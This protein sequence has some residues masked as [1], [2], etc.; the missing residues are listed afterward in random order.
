MWR[1][2]S[3]T[4]LRLPAHGK[5][6][7]LSVAAG[8][9]RRRGAYGGRNIHQ[10]S[11]RGRGL[12]DAAARPASGRGRGS[13]VR[14]ASRRWPGLAHRHGQGGE[15]SR[16]R[17]CFSAAAA[18]SEDI[19]KELAAAIFSKKL[20]VPVRIEDIQPSGAF[21][22]LASRSNWVNAFENTGA[23]RRTGAEP[24]QTGQGRHRRWKASSRSTAMLALAPGRK[25]SPPVRK[26][27]G[28]RRR[29]VA[30]YR[31]SRRGHAVSAAPDAHRIARRH[32]AVRSL[33]R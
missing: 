2:P 4:F 21:Y 28:R 23:A 6:S 19:A 15:A 3:K 30:H 14:R 16:I 18:E 9:S 22:D 1:P 33:E 12:G 20:V 8:F 27:W 29:G 10:L 32:V 24:G 11:A 13:L 17:C 31:G 25:T 7:M 26:T 5:S